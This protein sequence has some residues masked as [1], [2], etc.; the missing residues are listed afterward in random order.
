[1]IFQ[2]LRGND[3]HFI[4][5]EIGKNCK[6]K[7]LGINC[8]PNNMERYMAFMLGNNLVFLD[9]FQFMSSGLDRLAENLP[10]DKYKYTSGIFKNEQ[11][12]LMKKKG[13]YP[14][15]FMD[16]FQKFD[17]KELSKKDEFL[18]ML[19]QEGITNKQ[20]QHAQQVWDTF[21]TKSMG[22]YH[23]LYLKV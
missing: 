18:S 23:D 16:S 7:N 15:V 14:Y 21:K 12:A 8:I 20:Y 13:V 10:G 22:E 9:S 4:M 19:T 2:N 11:L 5:Q 17:Y 1:M 3:A 6:E